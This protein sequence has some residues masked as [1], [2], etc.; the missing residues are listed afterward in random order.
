MIGTDVNSIRLCI[1]AAATVVATA[2]SFAIESASG[3]AL[4]QR[5]AWP[6]TAPEATD[7]LG[8]DRAGSRLVAVGARGM[9]A[10][11][12]D[13]G[14]TWRQ[15]AAVPVRSAL[16]A[17]HFVDATHGWAVG[18]DGTIISST[19]GG[20]HWTLQ[21]FDAT[22]D[23][24]L[25]SVRFLDSQHGVAVGLWS[26]V[27]I[28]ADGGAT[29]NVVKMPLPPDGGRA[30]RNLLQVF[31]GASR[32]L[33]VAAEKGT[34]LRSTDAGQTWTYH[35]TGYKGSLWTGTVTKDGVILVGGLRGNLRRSRDG[36]EHWDAVP[37]GTSSSLT[38]LLSDGGSVIGVGLDGATITSD[39]DGATFKATQRSDRLSLTAVVRTSQGLQLFSEQGVVQP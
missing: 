10:L 1:A 9:V 28:T 30:D 14:H 33:Y 34:V 36:G 6:T 22:V 39:D 32:T 23:Q 11:S 2:S 21:R 25:F 20:E 29:W 18:H 8:A 7:I 4:R 31:S 16:T 24:P 17:V 27:L 37:S 19:D 35:D 3:V 12:D 26:L 5:P 15:A 13:D 38:E